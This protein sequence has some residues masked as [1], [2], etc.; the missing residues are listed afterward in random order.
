MTVEVIY[1]TDPYCTWCWGSEPITRKIKEVFGKQVRFT[2]IMG[3]LVE[4]ISN[5]YDPSNR[6]GG[7]NMFEQVALHWEDA[8]RRHGMP[9]DGRGFCDLKGE[10]RSTY[11]ASIAFK[12]AQI[13]DQV[14]AERFLRRMR[15]AASAERQA[16][17]R[18][19]VQVELAKDT[20]L[21][22]Q[23]FLEVLESGEAERT[24]QKDLEHARSMGVT[25]FPT[26]L[27]TNEK[28]DDIWL[29]GFQPFSN[30]EKAL[31]K[32]DPH[33]KAKAP[34]SILEFIRKYKRVATMEVMEVFELA[35]KE[36]FEELWALEK[37]GNIKKIKA[38]NGYFWDIVTWKN[39]KK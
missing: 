17:S 12:A 23:K 33:L 36:A 22:S 37:L 25:S 8:S 24:F 2:Y 11:P 19:D 1:F 7:E 10:F 39:K 5:F 27:L 29:K 21:D 28:G 35:E 31:Q 20:G 9:V 34:K 3:G 15:E 16:I 6:I 14:L 13:Q 4:D 18:V 26:F 30:F 32:L 38:G